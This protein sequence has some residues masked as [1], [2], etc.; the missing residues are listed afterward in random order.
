[1]ATRT[2]AASK[3]RRTPKWWARLS[4]EELL[5][6][7][8]C[9]LGLKL[10]DAAVLRPLEK[11]YAELEAKGI[12]FRPHA[13][14]AEE[15]FSPDGVPGIAMPFYLLHPRLRRLERRF[16][17]EVEG[18]N[19]N[20]LMRLLRHEAGH[21][22]DTAYRLRRRRAWRE[23][24][25]YASE[26]YPHEYRPRP[27]SRRY[28]QHLG[29]WY[30]QSHPAEDFAE[31]FA[32]WLKPGSRWRSEY[33]DWPALAKL[34]CV[35]A[36]MASVRGATPH[37]RSRAHIEPLAENRRTLREHYAEK[38]RRYC[39][40]RA[41]REDPGLQ[42]VFTRQPVRAPAR[43]A[44]SLLR[45]IRVRLNTR[46]PDALD[47]SRYD[48]HQVTRRLISRCRALELYVRGDRRNAEKRAERLVAKLVA[49]QRSRTGPRFAV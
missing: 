29:A 43:S 40:V 36:L 24:F 23:T 4:D 35:D 49:L 38:V 18:G 33:A 27:G 20:W 19:Q 11:L 13:W 7:R 32:V 10:E 9:D 44:A 6:L 8:F 2:R 47:A 39:A 34:E 45:Q 30:A 17:G 5:D 22:V 3:G 16:M 15:W 31:T 42:R 28:V 41:Q 25:G 37:V 12:R 46:L 1:M 48:I 21:A 14:I 26:P